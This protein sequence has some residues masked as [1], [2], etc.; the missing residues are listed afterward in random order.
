MKVWDTL[1]NAVITSATDVTTS[2]NVTYTDVININAGQSKTYKVTVDVDSDNEDG[3]IL[4]VQ[5]L[6]FTLGDVKNLDNNQNVA[7]ADIV[8]NATVSG[9]EM[10]SRAP[11]LDVQLS[12]T[13]SSQ[14][15]VRGTSN[16]SLVGVSFRAISADVKLSSVKI[17]ASSTVGAL[18]S[19]EVQSLGLYDGST[20]VSSL[21]SLS[22]DGSAFS[23]IFDGLNLTIAKGNTKTLTLKGNVSGDATANDAYYF[24]VAAVSTANITAT[25]TSGNSITLS[26]TAA[27]SGNT[28]LLTVTTSGDVTVVK[29][30]DDTDSEAGIVVAGQE[31][32]LAKF[33]FTSTNETMTV[34]KMQLL[35]V[36]TASATATS[37]ASSDEAP[38]VKLYDGSTQIGSATGYNVTGSGDNSGVV[39][40]TD[41]GWQIPKDTNK[42]LI[43]KGALNTISAGAD[44]GASVYASIMAAGFESQGSTAL[45]TSITAAT[46]NQ[47][48]VYKTKPTLSLPT[49]TNTG[50]N[51][52]TASTPITA[53][54][55]R[56]AADSAGNISWKKAVFQVA[57][58]NATMSAASAANVVLKDVSTGSSLTLS[59]V[60]SGSTSTAATTATITGG[61]TGYVGLELTTHEQISSNSY[62]DYDLQL[63]FSDISTTN[64]AASAVA[65]LYREETTIANA[66]W[67]AGIAG[68]AVDTNMTPSFI[69]S[70]Q[71]VTTHS[72]S[73][74]DWANGVFVKPGSFTDVVNSLRN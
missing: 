60:Y 46:G 12:S 11:S 3:D 21:K 17:T 61:N 39:Y 32:A 62:K 57:M 52:L 1:S 36:P 51:S 48:V 26:G 54:R 63:P 8:P 44:A 56:V 2:S 58:A 4:K 72:S 30:P 5:L 15:I 68:A 20:L 45:D 23:A 25:D 7:L 47:K 34:N 13:P 53:L 27:N 22:A 42:T 55:F 19:G 43:V 74:A 6:A 33:K 67:Y 24:Y 18:T 31:V 29:S 59:T 28:I 40:I 9:N 65:K 35:V 50:D 37:S 70:D 71:S 64:D 41:L 66:T 16:A 10:T 14:T 69:W 38:T 49:Q 73:T